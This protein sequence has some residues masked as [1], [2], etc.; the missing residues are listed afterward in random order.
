MPQKAPI[1]I[2]PS[3]PTFTTPL[4]SETMPPSAPKVSGVANTNTCAIRSA[5]KT[6]WRFPELDRVER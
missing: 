3:S 5:A 6:T 1:S 4:R 2:I